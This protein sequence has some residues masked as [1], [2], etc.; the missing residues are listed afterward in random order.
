MARRR[1]TFKTVGK[2]SA[3]V[4]S[5]TTESIEP[6]GLD[7]PLDAVVFAPNSDIAIEATETTKD[8]LETLAADAVSRA[9][10]RFDT[11]IVHADRCIVQANTVVIPVTTHDKLPTTR[12][13]CRPLLEIYR[14]AG[15]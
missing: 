7:T 12:V 9:G 4:Q 1:A 15:V 14:D 11:L 2:M 10:I 5:G 3:S 8:A 13:R 6:V